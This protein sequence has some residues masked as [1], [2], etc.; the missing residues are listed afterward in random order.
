MVLE[1]PIGYRLPPNLSGE[2]FGTRVETNSLGMRDREVP[3]RKAPGEFRILMIGDSLWF[4]VGVEYEESI[5]YQ[6]EQVAN[7]SAPPGVRYRTLNMGVPSYNTEQELIQLETVG[8]ALRPDLAVL[9]FVRNDIE[10]AMWV[11]DKRASW[12][13]NAAQRSYAASLAFSLYRRL[14]AR[15]GGSGGG[16]VQYGSYTEDNP[17]WQAIDRALTGIHRILEDAGVPLMVVSVTPLD[18]PHADLLR[19]VA[20]REGFPLREID[21]LSDPRWAD[22]P[23][24]RFTNSPSDSHCNPEGCRNAAVLLHERLLEEGLLPAQ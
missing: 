4:S 7:A 9:V 8:M 3:A 15:L 12:V 11:F 22:M 1:E 18:G 10:P 14:E 19:D 2:F 17:R 6:L 23:R 13:A 5:P 16:Q 21:V 24:E 20:E